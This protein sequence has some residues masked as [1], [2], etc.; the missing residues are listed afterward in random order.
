M[1]PPPESDFDMT[2]HA[3]GPLVSIHQHQLSHF[4]DI[5][6][7]TFYYYYNEI[8]HVVQQQQTKGRTD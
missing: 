5:V 1:M 8:V 4:Q 7:T 6:F 2:F 3:H